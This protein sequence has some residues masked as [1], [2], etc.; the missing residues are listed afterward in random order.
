MGV[1]FIIVACIPLILIRR[2]TNLS[3]LSYGQKGDRFFVLLNF[4]NYNTLC[5]VGVNAL[6]YAIRCRNTY[7]RFQVTSLAKAIELTSAEPKKMMLGTPMVTLMILEM[8]R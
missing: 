3:P 2:L 5:A 4:K 6:R 8:N 1:A 7:D